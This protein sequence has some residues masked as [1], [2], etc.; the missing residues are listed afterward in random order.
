MKIRENGREI[1]VDVYAIYWD[2]GVRIYSVIPYE[3][4]EGLISISE[5]ESVVVDNNINKFIIRKSDYEN[6]IIIHEAADKDGLIY[7]L[8]DHDAEAMIEFKRRLVDYE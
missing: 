7:K 8:I 5:N 1:P 3:G 2:N 6:D 4:Y